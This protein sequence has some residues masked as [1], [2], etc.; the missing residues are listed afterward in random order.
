MRVRILGRT[1]NLRFGSVAELGRDYGACDPPNLRG[2]EIII[3]DDLR[4]REL[5]DTFIHESLHAGAW[6]QLDEAFIERLATDVSKLLWTPELLARIL[7]DDSVREALRPKVT[8]D[9]A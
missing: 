5:V 2:K 1:W 3:R 6:H 9:P 7:D 4:G 8:P